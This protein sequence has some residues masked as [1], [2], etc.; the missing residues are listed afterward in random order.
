MI[1]RFVPM[2]NFLGLPA[3]SVPV[4]YERDTGLPI[5]FHF[6]GDA[7]SEHLLIRL[8]RTAEKFLDDVG[9]GRRL[10][11]AENYFDVLAPWLT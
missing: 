11:P 8:G 6:M 7:W 3:L 4:G 2:A 5:G 1:M 9:G 10:P